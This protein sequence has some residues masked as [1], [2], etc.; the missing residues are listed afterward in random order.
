[1][2]DSEEPRDGAHLIMISPR[3]S[4]PANFH[5]LEPDVYTLAYLTEYIR[6]DDF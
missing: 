2:H 4:A 1:M 6:A 3:L 5:T